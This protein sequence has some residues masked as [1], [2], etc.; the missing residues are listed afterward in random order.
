MAVVYRDELSIVTQEG[1]ASTIEVQK[2]KNNDEPQEELQ[3]IEAKDDKGTAAQA[4]VRHNGEDS[5][6]LQHQRE[7]E[8]ASLLKWMRRLKKQ[9]KSNQKVEEEE[10]EGTSMIV[11]GG[12]KDTRE[13]EDEAGAAQGVNQLAASV[14]V[15]PLQ[16]ESYDGGGAPGPLGKTTPEG[17]SQGVHE[18]LPALDTSEQVL[19]SIEAIPRHAEQWRNEEDDS[20]GREAIA[21][22]EERCRRVVRVKIGPPSSRPRWEQKRVRR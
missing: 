15:L 14:D 20:A 6:V 1:V 9:V 2:D 11:Q 19:H 18:D 13:Q 21:K 7:E 12:G 22:E 4:G 3:E 17:A 10:K 5:T 16:D 8:Q